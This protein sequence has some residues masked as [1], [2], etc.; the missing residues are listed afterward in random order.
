MGNKKIGILTFCRSHN[1]GAV[2]Q[3]YASQRCIEKLGSSAEI[4]DYT[5]TTKINNYSPKMRVKSNPIYMLNSIVRFIMDIKLYRIRYNEFNKFI[6]TKL[7]LSTPYKDQFP[8]CMDNYDVIYIGSDQVWRK[9]LAAEGYDFYWGN[10]NVP[11]TTKIISYAASMEAKELSNEDEII[12]KKNLENFD[13]ISVRESFLANILQPLTDKHISVVLDP[14]LLLKKEDYLEIASDCVVE[15]DYLLIY[16][17][18]KNPQVDIVAR[19]IAKQHNL[20]LVKIFIPL[21][22]N[23]VNRFNSEFIFVS[24]SPAEFLRLFTDAKY[25]V[26]NSFHGTAFSLIFEK[27]F[28][29][30]ET[31]GKTSRIESLLQLVGIEDKAYVRGDNFGQ[32]NYNKLNY[33]DINEKLEVYRQKSID[34]IKESIS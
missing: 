23:R 2:L 29:S 16:E 10:I 17:L 7:N 1:W 21:I 9:N 19:Q 31:A 33:N 25:V 14:T 26:T 5:P 3:T 6:S 30:L 34:Y 15:G 11:S 4:I 13:S 27:Q 18:L 28:L 24:P 20:K 12:C 32:E 8:E 22:S